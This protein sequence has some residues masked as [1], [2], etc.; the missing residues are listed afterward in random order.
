MK[1]IY[2]I[3]KDV[4]KPAGENNWITMTSYEFVMFMK[5]DEG[6][7]RKKNFAQI[8]ACGCDDCIIVAECDK[9]I[10]DKIR[11]EK[12]AHDRFVKNNASIGY[13]VFSYNEQE[14]SEDDLS[15]EELIQDIKINVEETIIEKHCIESLRK[16]IKELN[17]AERDLINHLYLNE[18]TITARQYAKELGVAETTINYR[19]DNVLIKIKKIMNIK[20]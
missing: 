9:H 12:K 10:R 16:A 4:N 6:R 13:T 5:T 17:E 8:D 14:N 2:L 20:K 19:R 18:N 11:R 7:R 3:K 15:G 1:K